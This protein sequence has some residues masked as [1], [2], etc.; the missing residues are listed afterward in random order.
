M[1][2]YLPR[3]YQ[4]LREGRA[5]AAPRCLI[6]RGILEVTATYARACRPAGSPPVP[7]D[8]AA[9]RAAT[10]APRGE[11]RAEGPMTEC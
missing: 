4:A 5:A 10:P 1:S 2:Q 6:H 11:G 3:Q 9:A 8:G 7:V